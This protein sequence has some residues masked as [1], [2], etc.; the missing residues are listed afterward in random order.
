MILSFRDMIDFF[1]RDLAEIWWIF[2]FR[3]GK[4]KN[5]R[6]LGKKTQVFL[7][8][9]SLKLTLSQK[10]WIAQKKN[11]VCKKWAS[12]QFQYTMQ[13]WPHLK[14]VEFLGAQNA[15]FGRPWPPN[16]IW[17]DMKFYAHY[18][19]SWLPMFYVKIK[20]RVYISVDITGP[21]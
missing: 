5:L 6:H 16:A 14:K 11:H 20:T 12:D 19:F 3:R 15:P 17:C 2:F 7:T 21:G 18:F 4:K 8:R 13:I 1:F 9:K 10:L